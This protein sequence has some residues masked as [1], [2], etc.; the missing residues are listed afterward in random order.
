MNNFATNCRVFDRIK[1]YFL[2]V[3]AENNSLYK[4]GSVKYS[5]ITDVPE[6]VSKVKLLTFKTLTKIPEG[7]LMLG[8]AT[9]LRIIHKAVALIS[10]KQVNGLALL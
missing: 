8:R 2:R 5:I 1:I 4:Y 7:V 9:H 3:F 10:K 6:N